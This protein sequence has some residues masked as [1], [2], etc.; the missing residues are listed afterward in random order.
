M[1][2]QGYRRDI[3]SNP[4]GYVSFMIPIDRLKI[5]KAEKRMTGFALRTRP[6]APHSGAVAEDQNPAAVI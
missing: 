4:W 5:L 3:L 2:R 1:A 6:T